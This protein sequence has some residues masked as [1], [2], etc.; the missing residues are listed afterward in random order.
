M[1]EDEEEE[2]LRKNPIY[3]V[4]QSICDITPA[5]FFQHQ[6]SV[7]L[8]YLYVDISAPPYL[9][10]VHILRPISICVPLFFAYFLLFFYMYRIKYVLVLCVDKFA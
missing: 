2:K 5:C 3:R 7:A 8:I 4:A 1:K 10:S 6:P 9:C